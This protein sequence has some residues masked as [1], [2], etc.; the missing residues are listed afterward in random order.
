VTQHGYAINNKCYG[1]SLSFLFLYKAKYFPPI[2]GM[3]TYLNANSLQFNFYPTEYIL[4][5]I[6][7]R[8]EECEDDS[9]RGT[10]SQLHRSV[11]ISEICNTAW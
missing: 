10:K 11:F 3:S 7:D 6:S 1:N 8:W 9:Q 5:V 2:I 4:K